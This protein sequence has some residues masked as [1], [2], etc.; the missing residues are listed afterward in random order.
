[1]LPFVL[2]VVG[3]GLAGIALGN[4]VEG[5]EQRQARLRSYARKLK[6]NGHDILGDM[7]DV[8]NNL[9]SSAL[10]VVDANPISQAYRFFTKKEF[11][12]EAKKKLNIG[13]HIAVDRFSNYT[14]H[15]IYGG[16]GRVIE[17]DDGEI[18]QSNL[19]KFIGD[20][21]TLYKVESESIYSPEKIWKRACSRLGERSYNLLWNNCEHFARWC[22]NGE[23]LVS[24][25]NGWVKKTTIRQIDESEVPPEILKMFRENKC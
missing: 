11:L 7:M 25:N 22:R 23:N 6:E 20:D 4:V 5:K 16:K 10:N 18:I 15:A 3:A 2:Y 21:V 8:S 9:E 14:H 17:Y 19:E 1:M 13:D 24:N 12:D